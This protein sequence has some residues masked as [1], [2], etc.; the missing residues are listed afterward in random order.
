LQTTLLGEQRLALQSLQMAQNSGATELSVILNDG[1][2]L[3][4]AKSEWDETKP[5][6]RSFDLIL[7]LSGVKIPVK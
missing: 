7:V 6:F 4:L 3:L 5:R 2:K 1:E